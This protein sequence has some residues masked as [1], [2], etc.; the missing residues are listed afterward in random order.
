MYLICECGF[1]PKTI[2]DRKSNTNG[3]KEPMLV[4]S[5]PPKMP[6]FFDP[7]RLKRKQAS[8]LYKCKTN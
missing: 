6:S 1:Y 3:E 5:L 8:V 4:L 7:V 2:G